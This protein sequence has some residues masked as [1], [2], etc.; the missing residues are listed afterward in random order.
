MN[1]GIALLASEKHPYEKLTPAERSFVELYHRLAAEAGTRAFYY[2]REI[3]T[4]EPR[5]NLSL[6]SSSK[7][8]T[9]KTNELVKLFGQAIADVHTKQG[10]G[11]ESIMKQFFQL[12][13][14][15]PIGRYCASLQ[16]VYY[17]HQW[18]SSYGGPAWGN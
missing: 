3:C 18:S 9:S 7:T 6:K 13:P 1:Q 17:K 4:R 2:L 12:T 11:E 5:H 10:H 8:L 16:H 15:A 14:D